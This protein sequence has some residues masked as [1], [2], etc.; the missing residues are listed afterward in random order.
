MHNEDKYSVPDWYNETPP[1]QDILNFRTALSQVIHRQNLDLS[2][3]IDQLRL[4][5]DA[6]REFAQISEKFRQVSPQ[7]YVTT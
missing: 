7:R 4:T 5:Q 6:A 1:L 3:K 2:S